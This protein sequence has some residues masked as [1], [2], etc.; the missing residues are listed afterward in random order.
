MP[1]SVSPSQPFSRRAAQ[2]QGRAVKLS[3]VLPQP[4][5]RPARFEE[6]LGAKF[7]AVFS[8]R[9]GP[10]PE[11]VVPPELQNST[12]LRLGNNG[13]TL[14]ATWYPVERARGVVV[15][16]PPWT[17]WGQT[18]F[19]R[20]GRIQALHEAGYHA[21]TLEMPGRGASDKGWGFSDRELET[22]LLDVKSRF[23]QLPLFVW[24]VSAGGY[25][26]HPVLTRQSWIRAAFFEDVAPHLFEWIWRTSP[27]GR[28]FFLV[29]RLLF[30]RIYRFL[31]LRRHAPHLRG[32]PVTY[33][34]GAEDRGI[35]AKSAKELAVSAGAEHLVVPGAGHLGSIKLATLEV[36]AAALAT[37]EQAAGG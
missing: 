30:P 7:L 4:L 1:C 17:S 2:P 36:V 28:P 12:E 16:L 29:L 24:G 26:A 34:W 35:P 37:F 8:P 9:L 31:D 22:A 13:P 33:V 27:L 18:Y 5:P 25:W 19:L 3:P 21:L 14:A 15:L 20:R 32:R 11:I 10:R 23:E 6:W